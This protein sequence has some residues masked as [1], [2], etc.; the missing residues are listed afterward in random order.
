MFDVA[1]IPGQSLADTPKNAPWE[2]PPKYVEPKEILVRYMDR[3]T[4]TKRTDA[5]MQILEEGIDVQTLTEGI[6]R[7]GVY[8]GIHTVDAGMII[9]PVIHEY[10]KTTADKLGIDYKT[11][12][13][14]PS[15]EERQEEAGKRKAIL[16][17][18]EQM[19]VQ[20][21]PVVEEPPM[22]EQPPMK[23]LM[24]RR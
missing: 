16:R 12:F 15:M 19:P 4:D 2:R 18:D 13:E 20:E 23:G 14:E 3:L 22:V 24:A 1:P 21:E 5:M 8:E 17:M 9:A 7:N 10:I 6:L 11:G